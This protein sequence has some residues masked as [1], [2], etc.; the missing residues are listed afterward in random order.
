MSKKQAVV[1]RSSTEAEYRSMASVVAE[2]Q[3]LRTLLN[4][5]HLPLINVPTIYCDNQSTVMLT[6]NP[7][8]H[9]RT[10]HFELDL[11]FV[12]EKVTQGVIAVHH[13]PSEEQTADVLTKA[14][15]SSRFPYLR[16]KLRVEQFNP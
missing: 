7:I 15:S 8:L 13:I 6:S 5:L 3:W 16:T 2:L 10:K 12:R 9:Q 1:S 4:E 11:H 14:V